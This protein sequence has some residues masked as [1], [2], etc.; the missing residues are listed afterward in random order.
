M[1]QRSLKKSY[2][3]NENTTYPNMWDTTK[4]VLRGK[5]PALSAPILKGL[6][7]TI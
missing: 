5:I 3:Q 7:S 2:E 6:K 4:A 1:G